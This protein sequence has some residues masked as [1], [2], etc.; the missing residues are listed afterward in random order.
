MS[1][2]ISSPPG[3]TSPALMSSHLTGAQLLWLIVATEALGF[4]ISLAILVYKRI[5]TVK[6]QVRLTDRPTRVAQQL[7]DISSD[8]LPSAD[9]GGTAHMEPMSFVLTV[10]AGVLSTL[11]SRFFESK[12]SMISSQALKELVVAQV[13]TEAGSQIVVDQS[14]IAQFTDSTLGEV[15]LLADRNHSLAVDNGNIRLRSDVP[16]SK[17]LIA[18]QVQHM[19]QIVELRR[20]ELAVSDANRHG[21]KYENQQHNASHMGDSSRSDQEQGGFKWTDSTLPRS[22]SPWD[23]AIRDM[24]ERVRDRRI[25]NGG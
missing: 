3:F 5:T 16:P 12:T 14:N 25:G 4:I 1:S 20:Q 15:Y 7:E 21:T 8:V 22:A 13:Q 6:R 9:E 2:L 23:A 18:F 19:R 24:H 10:A 11:I 17:D